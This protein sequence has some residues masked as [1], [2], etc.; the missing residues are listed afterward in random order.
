MLRRARLS[1]QEAATKTAGIGNARAELARVSD[2]SGASRGSNGT[3]LQRA[4]QAQAPK[5]RTQQ[6]RNGGCRSSGSPNRPQ[7]SLA[8][9]ADNDG[10]ND[11]ERPDPALLRMPITDVTLLCSSNNPI[12]DCRTPNGYERVPEDLNFGTGGRFIYLCFK[13]GTSAPVSEMEVL[14]STTVDTDDTAAKKKPVRAL[15]IFV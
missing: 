8:S 13:R 1:A 15:L 2:N 10:D 11:D 14:V 7:S 3:R 5:N 9:Q 4:A 6:Q 12:D